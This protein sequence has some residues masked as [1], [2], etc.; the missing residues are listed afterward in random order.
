MSIEN[1]NHCMSCGLCCIYYPTLAKQYK[2]QWA[3]VEDS[4]KDKV[5]RKLYKIT[6]GEV[7][8]S[9][10]R[11]AG[12]KS[13]IKDK[14]DKDWK[15]FRRCVALEGVARE[16]VSCNV[17]ENRPKVCSD[18]KPGSESCNQIRKWGNLKEIKNETETF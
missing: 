3:C 18:F 5:P 15:G 2:G 9:N 12:I 17:Y 7:I 10:Y 11:D 6:R 14:V 1:E 4:E 16:K 13:F 8:P